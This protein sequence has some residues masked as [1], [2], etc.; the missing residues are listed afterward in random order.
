MDNL[1]QRLTMNESLTFIHDFVHR[2]FHEMDSKIFMD[3]SM[4]RNGQLGCPFHK[5]DNFTSGSQR[6]Q[7][8]GNLYLH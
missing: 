1:N 4:S 3:L 6:I 7:V 2:P 5:M 8:T